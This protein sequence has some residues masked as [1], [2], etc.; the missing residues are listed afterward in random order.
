MLGPVCRTGPEVAVEPELRRQIIQAVRQ[1]L[2][3]DALLGVTDVPIPKQPERPPGPSP[4]SPEQKSPATQR[5]R[6]IGPNEEEK[7]RR[8]EALF[9]EHLSGCRKCSLARDRNTVVFGEG[10]PAAELVFVGEAP[11]AE[12]DRQ[13]RPFVGRAGQLLN[14]MIEAMGLTREEVY[15]CNVLKCRPPDNRTP[16]AD[17]IAACSPYLF[18]Q[19]RIIEPKIIVALGAPAAQTLLGTRQSI[20]ALR[21]QFHDFYPSGSALMGQPIKLLPTYHPAYLLRNPPD[22]RKAWEDLK[23]VMIELGLPIPDPYR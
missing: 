10:S 8:L 14:R 6:L 4:A 11:G 3:T 17:E 21:G 20:G 9:Q 23:L 5:R 16:S 7:A 1:N 12:E 18:D 19:L 2:Q 22:K 15:I 13:G